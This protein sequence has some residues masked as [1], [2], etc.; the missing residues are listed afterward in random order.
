MTKATAGVTTPLR[1]GFLNFYKT[2]SVSQ[3]YFIVLNNIKKIQEVALTGMRRNF[4]LG[5]LNGADKKARVQE[6]ILAL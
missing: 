3:K 6:R 2:N 5:R 4:L 1:V